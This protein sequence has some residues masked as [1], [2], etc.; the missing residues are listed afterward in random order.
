MFLLDE[1]IFSH[2]ILS[3]RESCLELAIDIVLLEPTIGR[4]CFYIGRPLKIPRLGTCKLQALQFLRSL[5]YTSQLVIL[6]RPEHDRRL[7]NSD[8]IKG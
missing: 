4:T 1:I 3:V 7:L 5:L 8:N 2:Y 6:D